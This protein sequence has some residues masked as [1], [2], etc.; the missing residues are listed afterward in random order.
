MNFSEYALLGY[1][2]LH[3]YYHSRDND[4]RVIHRK[5]STMYWESGVG[6]GR[7]SATLQFSGRPDLVFKIC[8]DKSLNGQWSI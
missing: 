7:E 1:S 8:S 5:Q 2:S 6:K 3:L 4:D